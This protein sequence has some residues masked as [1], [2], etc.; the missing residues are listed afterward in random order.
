MTLLFAL[1]AIP[2]QIPFGEG[3]PTRPPTVRFP[4]RNLSA[5]LA[6]AFGDVPSPDPEAAER[7]AARREID[8]LARGIREGLLAPPEGPSSCGLGLIPAWRLAMSVLWSALIELS[9]EHQVSGRTDAAWRILDRFDQATRAPFEGLGDKMGRYCPPG[10]PL[11]D[12]EALAGSPLTR[13]LFAFLE[14]L[15]R[16]AAR[17]AEGLVEAMVSRYPPEAGLRVLPFIMPGLSH[18]EVFGRG[19]GWRSRIA[20]FGLGPAAAPAV[21]AKFLERE[22]SLDHIGVG[23]VE[24]LGASGDP[25]AERLLESLAEEHARTP[26]ADWIRAVLANGRAARGR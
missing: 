24:L 11:T 10:P 4:S 26:T 14:V 9:D 23:L 22:K 13:D 6:L 8:A 17:D 20:L 18:D 1:L 2:V 19:A 7:E 3:G 25:E 21:R 16:E 5:T 15:R 12:R